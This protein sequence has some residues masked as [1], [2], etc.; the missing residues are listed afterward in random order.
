MANRIAVECASAFSC[1]VKDTDA[2][3]SELVS[4]L[5]QMTALNPTGATVD[6]T[7]DFSMRLAPTLPQT[8]TTM[9]KVSRLGTNVTRNMGA[10]SFTGG[11]IGG[12]LGTI[13]P[14]PGLGTAFGMQVGGGIGAL[15]GSLWGAKSG[16]QQVVADETRSK[17]AAILAELNK[18]L[19]AAHRKARITLDEFLSDSLGSVDRSLRAEIRGAVRRAPKPEPR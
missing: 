8:I 4:D 12:I 2:R 11:V 10:F 13:I 7:V 5:Q 14:V 19:P 9:E 3:I 1:L 6:V 18:H 17:R 16:L 15:L